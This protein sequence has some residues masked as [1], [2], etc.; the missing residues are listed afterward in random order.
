M[1]ELCNEFLGIRSPNPFWLASAPP[2][3]KAYN[4]NRAFEAGWGGAVWKTLGEAGDH[5]LDHLG[6]FIC[7]QL[8]CRFNVPG[9]RPYA[10]ARRSI[11]HLGRLRR[12][13]IVFS[14]FRSDPGA[15]L[16][17]AELMAG[18]LQPSRLG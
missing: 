18:R 3:D 4:V 14:W 10:S 16:C 13:M 6:A 9:G 12:L 11:V 2:T 15:A 5:G 7:S 17:N 1:A 8:C